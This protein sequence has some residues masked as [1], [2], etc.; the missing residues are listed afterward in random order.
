[1]EP[2]LFVG[3]GVGLTLG[4]LSPAACSGLLLRS[5]LAGES[6]PPGMADRAGDDASMGYWVILR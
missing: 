4:S 6:S 3:E 5:L 1:M 2:L